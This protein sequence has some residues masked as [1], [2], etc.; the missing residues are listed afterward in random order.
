MNTGTLGAMSSTPRTQAVNGHRKAVEARGDG[1]G[2]GE[3][4]ENTP[5]QPFSTL[6][7]L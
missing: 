4:A 6:P 3:A 1:R 5:E 7:M 2:G